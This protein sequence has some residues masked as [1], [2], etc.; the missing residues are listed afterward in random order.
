MY[1]LKFLN[2]AV[3]F[4][5]ILIKI[6]YMKKIILIVFCFLFLSVNAITLKGSVNEEYIP[7]GFYGSW[8]VISKLKSSNN[9]SIF[10]SESR[11]IWVLSGHDNVLILENLESGAKS[12]IVI[13]HKSKEKDA[14][15][16]EREKVVE[17]NNEKTVYKEI[18]EFLL[19]HNTF[20]G[21]DKFIVEN[22]SDGEL[23]KKSEATYSVSGIKISGT[24]PK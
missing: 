12:E 22:W 14:L 3:E 4:F 23:V 24:N 17:K 9:P 20:T 19:M 10:N 8:A 5:L 11:D 15:K 21:S 13:K 16:F 6:N 1:F 18:V 7:N 2:L